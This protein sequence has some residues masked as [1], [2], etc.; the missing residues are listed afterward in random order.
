VTAYLYRDAA[1]ADAA[2][3]AAFAERTFTD[4]FGHLYPPED[5]AAFVAEKYR[6]QVIAAELADPDTRYR[7]ALRDGVI[8]GYC[9][10]GA[11]DMDVDAKGALELHRLYVDSDTKGAGV[12]QALMDDA[13]VWARGKG[14]R[15]M[16][17]SV[18]ENNAR[19]QAFY[20]RYGF[21]HVGEHKFMV[22]R[23]DDRDLIWRLAL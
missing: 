4:T 1:T 10:M 21:E 19:A 18:W 9:K 23:V 7:L 3:I 15:A 11:I 20:R 22:G 5:L 16:Y 8:A 2:E 17:L 13:L 6:A 14:A 12:A